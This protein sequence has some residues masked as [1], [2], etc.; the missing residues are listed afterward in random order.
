MQSPSFP[1]FLQERPASFVERVARV[2]DAVSR[3]WLTRA[4]ALLR[5]YGI[6]ARVS[7]S[8]EELSCPRSE[9]AWFA[10]AIVAVYALVGVLGVGLAAVPL[11]LGGIGVA[12]MV[13]WI[14]WY[15]P[16]EA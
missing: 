3:S 13:A 15:W 14:G 6:S 16:D 2:R 11:V 7:S 10:A 8:V 4:P 1:S 12:L 5:S 9:R